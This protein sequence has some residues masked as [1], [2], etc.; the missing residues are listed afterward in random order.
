ME[1]DIIQEDLFEALDDFLADDDI[2]TTDLSDG[3]PDSGATSKNL[4]GD[5]EDNKL[6]NNHFN[7]DFLTTE[8]NLLEEN[9]LMKNE[10]NKHDFKASFY[11]NSDGGIDEFNKSSYVDKYHRINFSRVNSSFF[12]A[13]GFVY[14]NEVYAGDAYNQNRSIS[15]YLG[16]ISE[17]GESIINSNNEVIGY[18][19]MRTR[20]VYNVANKVVGYADTGVEAAVHILI[21]MYDGF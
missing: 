14:K 3:L 2:F 19:E 1:E 7:N 18:F 15:T 16:K 6:L 20:K 12:D 13:M 5:F 17:D 10:Y 8:N 4:L 11:T 9:S 21:N